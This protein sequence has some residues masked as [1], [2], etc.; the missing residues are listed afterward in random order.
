MVLDPCYIIQNANKM[1]KIFW[2]II[3]CGDV[4]EVKSGPA[5]N[6]VANSEL[7]AVTRRDERKAEDYAK[8]HGILKWYTDAGELINDPEVNAIYIATPPAYHEAY[9][10]QAFEAG[11]SVYVEKPMALDSIEAARMSKAAEENE[12]KI[13]VAHYRRAQPRFIKILKLIKEKVVGD[14]LSVNLQFRQAYLP[15]TENTWRTNPAISGGGLF[16]DLA[17]HQLDLMLYFFGPPLAISGSSINRANLYEADDYANAEILFSKNILFKGVWDF[18]AR[19]EDE[20]DICQIEGTKGLI[21]FAVFGSL[22]E[23]V[24]NGQTKLLEFD[25]LKHV[26]QPMIEQVVKYFLDEV[27]NPC[28]GD[29]GV[30]VMRMIDRI[31]GKG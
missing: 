29:D 28:P 8:R 23:V 2:G 11:K 16:H 30:E 4:T 10:I 27:I 26:Q 12:V 31:C 9:A 22:C 19:L 7:V 17:P 1:K 6:L 20:K 25:E 13:S 14:I 24:I 18:N 21:R 15:G 5:F 3:G